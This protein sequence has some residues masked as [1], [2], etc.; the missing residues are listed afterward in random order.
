MRAEEAYSAL[1]R[2]CR[3]EALL[4]SCAELLGGD[5]LTHLPVG[6]VEHRGN[7]LAYLAG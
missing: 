3:E 4:A 6:G 5:E 2:R 1:I 7:Q